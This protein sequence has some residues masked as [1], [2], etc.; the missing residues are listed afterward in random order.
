MFAKFIFICHLGNGDDVSCKLNKL[1]ALD[2][3]DA[4]GEHLLKENL[5]SKRIG[6][7]FNKY[8]EW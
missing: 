4:L 1:K 6:P 8:V 2:D 3:L 7:Q 5:V